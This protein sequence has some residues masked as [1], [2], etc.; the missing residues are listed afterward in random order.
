MTCQFYG[1][2]DRLDTALHGK[3]IFKYGYQLFENHN[4]DGYSPIWSTPEYS[5]YWSHGHV[6]RS[7]VDLALSALH[8]ELLVSAMRD[9][10]RRHYKSSWLCA[11][12]CIFISL[13]K[14]IRHP[15]ESQSTQ[16]VNMTMSPKYLYTDHDSMFSTHITR[17]PRSRLVTMLLHDAWY[18]RKM[19][20]LIY[21]ARHGPHEHLEEEKM[22][23]P[24]TNSQCHLHQTTNFHFSK[25]SNAR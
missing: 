24:K 17:Y 12:V 5:T 7:V 15:K 16:R 18:V 10:W 25:S 9:P 23:Y 1:K 20:K 14:T 22:V 8:Y 3:D 6:T 19:V 4:Y 21:L 13:F 11:N 2:Q